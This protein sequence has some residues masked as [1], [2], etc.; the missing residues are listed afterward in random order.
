MNPKPSTDPSSSGNFSFESCWGC[1]EDIFN[2]IGSTTKFA[3]I[4][5]DYNSDIRDALL[6]EPVFLAH[7]QKLERM[8]LEWEAESSLSDDAPREMSIN[9]SIVFR[10]AALLFLYRMVWDTRNSDSRVQNTTS[11]LLETLG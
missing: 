7:A 8:M 1:H 2:F 5:R 11:S 4:I 9:S 6:C 3:M 10:D